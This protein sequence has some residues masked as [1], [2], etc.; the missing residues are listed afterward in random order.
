MRGSSVMLIVCIRVYIHLI[1]KHIHAHNI[2]YTH[3]IPS[4]SQIHLFIYRVMIYLWNGV[5]KKI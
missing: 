3:Q 5:I 1:Y 2:A 4:T